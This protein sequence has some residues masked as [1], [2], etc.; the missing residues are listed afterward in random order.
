LSGRNSTYRIVQF[1]GTGS[2]F[3]GVPKA[4]VCDNLK[5]AAKLRFVD[6]CI[7]DIDFASRRGLP[8]PA[9]YPA[10]RARRLAESP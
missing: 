6:A 10:A 2:Y 1:S 7:E 3:G 5:A 8:G 4:I 9:Q